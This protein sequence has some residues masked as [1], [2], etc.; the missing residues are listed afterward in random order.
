MFLNCPGTTLSILTRGLICRTLLVEKTIYD[1]DV[2]YLED[3][4]YASTVAGLRNLNNCMR[5]AD[6]WELSSGKNLPKL[7]LVNVP[8]LECGTSMP[9]VTCKLVRP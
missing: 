3:A 2:K 7:G 5:P 8:Q 6:G 1:L 9:Q 4:M